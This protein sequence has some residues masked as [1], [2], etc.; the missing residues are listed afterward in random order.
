M[1]LRAQGLEIRAEGIRV[2]DV[3]RGSGLRVQKLN[4][5]LPECELRLVPDAQ[6]CN[7]LAAGG[8]K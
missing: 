1:R 3:I 7:R 6:L 4:I 2:C 8:V 5:W